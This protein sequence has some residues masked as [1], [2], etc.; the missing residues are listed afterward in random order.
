MR[1]NR[2]A[3]F[4]GLAI[5]VS[6][7][8]VFLQPK[9]AEAACGKF[10]QCAS[11]SSYNSDVNNNPGGV[12]ASCANNY[13]TRAC[14][15]ERGGLAFSIEAQGTYIPGDSNLPAVVVDGPNHMPYYIVIRY[16]NTKTGELGPVANM[17]MANFANSKIWDSLTG[18]DNV[19]SFSQ[20][21]D[22]WANTYQIALTEGNQDVLKYG[23]LALLM[24]S[25]LAMFEYITEEDLASLLSG[26]VTVPPTL[27]PPI[28]PPYCANDIRAATTTSESA[29]MNLSGKGSGNRGWKSTG[30]SEFGGSAFTWAK[31]GDSVIFRH[32]LTYCNQGVIDDAG[33]VQTDNNW[34]EIKA[35]SINPDYAFGLNDSLFNRRITLDKHSATPSQVARADSVTSWG[36]RVYSPSL[37]PTAGSTYSCGVNVYRLNPHIVPGYQ[38]HGFTTATGPCNASGKTGVTNEAG[39]EITQTLEYNLLRAYIMH[40]TL[41]MPDMD[42]PGKSPAHPYDSFEDGNPQDLFFGTDNYYEATSAPGIWGENIQHLCEL[43]VD[44][45]VQVWVD[46][47]YDTDGD[48]VPDMGDWVDSSEPEIWHHNTLKPYRFEGA[49]HNEPGSQ[50]NTVTVKIPYNFETTTTNNLSN[51]PVYGGE[52]V[53]ARFNWAIL[54][55]ENGVINNSPYATITPDYSEVRLIEFTLPPDDNR[56][57][58]GAIDPRDPCAYYGATDCN[59]IESISGPFNTTGD[60]NG[61][62][63]SRS[64]TRSIPDTDAIG[65]KY[66]VAIGIY[67]ASSHV[68]PG[69]NG[70]EG[71]GSNTDNRWNIAGAS[72][73]VIA[74]KPNFQTWGAGIYTKGSITTAV[75]KKQVNA[76]FGTY[77]PNAIFGSWSDFSIIALGDVRGTASAAGFGYI[78]ALQPSTRDGAGNP[79]ANSGASHT[80]KLCDVSNLTIAKTTCND[81]YTGNSKITISSTIADRFR[82]RYTSDEIAAKPSGYV[83]NQTRVDSEYDSLG[84]GVRYFRIDGDATIDGNIL[85]GG[86][87]GIDTLVV[88]ATGTVTIRGNICYGDTTC[89]ANGVGNTYI[90]GGN[91][92]V[93]A[94]R[95][96][97]TDVASL[98]Q[99]LIFADNINIE[100]QVSQID[101]WLIAKKVLNTCSNFVSGSSDADTCASTLTVNG[102]VYAGD[103][104]LNRTAG[105]NGGSGYSEGAMTQVQN[106]ANDGSITPAEIFNLRPDVYYWSYA[107]AQRYSQAVVT[108]TREL[109]PRY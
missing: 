23:L 82:A 38:T 77:T 91:R 12:S 66:C 11:D 104:A 48:G 79:T 73:S 51:N 96:L 15:N 83:V 109:A 46:N 22:I 98:P 44:K 87:T 65:T 31:P 64:Y 78:S 58:S 102:P 97:Y 41:W 3:F 29:V 19:I 100:Q 4:A 13:Y 62:S 95:K 20:A 25:D 16:V 74:K 7:G 67:P 72:C 53:G 92:S 69:Q 6:C 37:N 39:K 81:G 2:L 5:I 88:H 27:T 9:I 75:S 107:Q 42:C 106:L 35:T 101:G 24:S 45:Y 84:S 70:D 30:D 71:M 85:M 68:S 32:A 49:T 36:F 43:V 89:T 56:D 33:N 99:V 80:A 18:Y 26:R 17:E 86:G 14:G 103:L 50:M 59:V 90:R 28:E 76:G 57:V 8:A 21:L 52:S 94:G 60:Y 63:N 47:L 10:E 55:R 40:K 1:K 54:P 61:D 108:Y 34:F 93:D 105:A